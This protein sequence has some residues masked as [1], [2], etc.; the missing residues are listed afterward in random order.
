[1]SLQHSNSCSELDFDF[2]GKLFESEI[3]VRNCVIC[4]FVWRK[5]IERDISH[6]VP[7]DE[8]SVKAEKKRQRE[9]MV[10]LNSSIISLL[11]LFT[12]KKS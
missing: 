9:R 11:S 10:R 7:L 12:F 5:K 4:R 6:G 1:M 2:F 8:F 3:L